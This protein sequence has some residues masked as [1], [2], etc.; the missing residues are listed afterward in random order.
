MKIYYLF[1]MEQIILFMTRNFLM[2]NILEKLVFLAKDG[3]TVL[4][5][6]E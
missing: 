2:M 3:D 1:C 4:G 5:Q 6:K